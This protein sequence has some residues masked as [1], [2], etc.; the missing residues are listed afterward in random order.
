MP[1]SN[2]GGG[3]QR[4][5]MAE[6]PIYWSTSSRPCLLPLG[7]DNFLR[8]CNVEHPETLSR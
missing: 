7:A 2:E 3:N 1:N 6:A 5:S 8:P 4:N